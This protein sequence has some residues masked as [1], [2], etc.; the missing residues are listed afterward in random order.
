MQKNVR[1]ERHMV[2][3]IISRVTSVLCGRTNTSLAKNDALVEFNDN[4]ERISLHKMLVVT[5]ILECHWLTTVSDYLPAGVVHT[6]HIHTHTQVAGLV[7]LT[8]P[9]L[10]FLQKYN[11]PIMQPEN[12]FNQIVLPAFALNVPLYIMCA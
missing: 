6:T 10:T 3:T 11:H 4:T 5:D 8:W 7:S 9:A 2:Y 12:A 1:I